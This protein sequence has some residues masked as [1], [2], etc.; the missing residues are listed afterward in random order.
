MHDEQDSKW[1]EK[2]CT[3][4]LHFM[5]SNTPTHSFF[6]VPPG[7]HP[8]TM[9][10]FV[11]QFSSLV[12]MC[13][14]HLEHQSITIAELEILWTMSIQTGRAVWLYQSTLNQVSD[15]LAHTVYVY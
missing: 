14:K 7:S 2:V 3:K 12:H 10:S 6:K 1:C 4:Q 15:S 13:T 5:L 9:A 11:T 8:R